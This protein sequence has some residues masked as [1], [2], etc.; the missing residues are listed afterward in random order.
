MPSNR[1]ALTRVRLDGYQPD[2]CVVG[3]S[4]EFASVVSCDFLGVPQFSNPSERWVVGAAMVLGL[5]VVILGFLAIRC[6]REICEKR[7][8]CARYCVLQL[9][10]LS[11]GPHS[12][13]TF[14]RYIYF[15][16]QEDDRAAKLALLG[17]MTPGMSTETTRVHL[18]TWLPSIVRWIWLLVA[19]SYAIRVIISLMFLK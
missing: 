4:R 17:N 2:T 6:W 1:D 9:I 15:E 5:P 7:G 8:E 11:D 18:G 10:K 19:I 3:Y 14:S 16:T 13:H 12:E